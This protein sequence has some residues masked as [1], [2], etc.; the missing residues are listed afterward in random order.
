V[1]SGF[2]HET[3]EDRLLLAPP[4]HNLDTNNWKE[5]TSKEVLSAVE[6]ESSASEQAD[7]EA[8]RRSLEGLL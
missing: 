4:E 1:P 5:A 8:F 6:P 7:L 3:A 2:L